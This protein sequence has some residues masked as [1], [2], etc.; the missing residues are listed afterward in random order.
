MKN[1]LIAIFIFLGIVAQFAVFSAIIIRR[2]WT[3]RYGEICRFETAPVDPFDAFRGQYVRLDYKAFTR[4]VVS[5]KK[6]SQNNWCYLSLATDTNGFS[7]VSS[8]TDSK[9]RSG[10]FIRS[11][12]QWSN[13]EYVERP[14]PDNKHHREGTG[15]WTIHLEL[16]F[17]RYYMPE[18]LAPRERS[19]IDVRTVEPQEKQI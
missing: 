15:K 18:K 16:P 3:L 1:K 7:I 17:S 4:G 6:F 8:I 13:E 2:E 10:T 5:A 19:R 11:R 12:V 9:P 14:T